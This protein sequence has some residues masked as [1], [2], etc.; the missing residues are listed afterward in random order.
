MVVIYLILLRP[1]ICLSKPESTDVSFL[2]PF[3]DARRIEKKIDWM[4]FV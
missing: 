2:K 3:A 1:Q 4:G